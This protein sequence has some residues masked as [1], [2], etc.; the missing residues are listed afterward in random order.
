MTVNIET[1]VTRKGAQFVIHVEDESEL[2]DLK[3]QYSRK[4]LQ[5]KLRMSIDK[6]PGSC[7]DTGKGT[8]V[9]ILI[10]GQGTLIGVLDEAKFAEWKKEPKKDWQHHHRTHLAGLFEELILLMVLSD[11]LSDLNEYTGPTEEQAEKVH[12]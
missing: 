4:E 8:K 12:G 7:G 1:L 10:N 6:F 3:K 2:K 5:Q 9:H 11:L